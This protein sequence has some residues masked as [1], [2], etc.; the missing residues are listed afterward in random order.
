VT[1]EEITSEFIAE[2][3]NNLC[4]FMPKSH[5]RGPYSK[6]QL[7]KRRNEVYRLHFEYGYSA[8]KIAQLM[9]INRNTINGDIKNWY[10]KISNK[11]NTLDP[12]SMIT[13]T[14]ERLDI[15]RTR[16]REYLDKVAEIQEKI[17][18]ERMICDIDCKMANIRQKVI[19]SS[20]GKFEYGISFLNEYLKSKNDDN[21][22]LTFYDKI[23]ISIPA[24]KKID[25]IINE[26]EKNLWSRQN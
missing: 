26:D 8:R 10:S 17:P 5:K 12:E 11:A 20:S 2:N 9:N 15:Q 19:D 7:E 1:F 13:L 14:I 6:Q 22:F 16:L 18:L 3:K 24:K 25:K 4:Q 23:K 21:R